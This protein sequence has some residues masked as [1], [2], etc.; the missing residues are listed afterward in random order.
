MVYNIKDFKS[1]FVIDGKTHGIVKMEHHKS[2]QNGEEYIRFYTTSKNFNGFREV[3]DLSEED[4]MTF[5]QN[6]GCETIYIGIRYN[7]Y[8]KLLNLFYNLN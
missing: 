6:Y 7:G 2:A 8:D 1:V 5:L 4:A 3:F